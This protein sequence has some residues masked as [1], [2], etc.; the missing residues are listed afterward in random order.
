MS[1]DEKRELIEDAPEVVFVETGD[2]TIRTLSLESRLENA[3]CDELAQRVAY[4]YHLLN[5]SSN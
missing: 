5:A 4:R 2:K 3:N 1:I